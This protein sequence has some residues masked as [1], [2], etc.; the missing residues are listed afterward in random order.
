[1]IRFMVWVTIRV[2]VRVR[3]TV[4]VMV[5][6]L[7][8]AVDFILTSVYSIDVS[9]SCFEQSSIVSFYIFLP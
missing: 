1:M 5:M 4:T 2:R 7:N 8:K 3:V 9:N 6:A